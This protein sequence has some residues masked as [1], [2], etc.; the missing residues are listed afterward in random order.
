[1]KSGMFIEFKL[2]EMGAWTFVSIFVYKVSC[3]FIESVLNAWISMFTCFLIKMRIW[4]MR[5]LTFCLCFN[6]ILHLLLTN[7]LICF[8]VFLMFLI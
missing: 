7:V 3:M 6:S 1:M 8:R 5:E 4:K 2:R